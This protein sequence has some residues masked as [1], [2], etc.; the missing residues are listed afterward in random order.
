[1]SISAPYHIGELKQMITLD[2]LKALKHGDRVYF[3]QMYKS[4]GSYLDSKGR[5]VSVNAK[6]EGNKVRQFRVSGKVQTWKTRPNDVKV[7]VKYG[8]YDNAYIGTV[9]DCEPLE[10]FYLTEEEAMIELPPVI[11]GRVGTKKQI[12]QLNSLL[13]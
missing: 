4:V 11:K 1:M 6:T 12:K 10:R 8:M 2:Q 3:V 5:I 9:A 13:A 7:P